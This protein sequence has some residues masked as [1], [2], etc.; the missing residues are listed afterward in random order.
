MKVR[1]TRC[2]LAGIV[3]LMASCSRDDSGRRALLEEA[4]RT[5]VEIARGAVV[6]DLRAPSDT[7]RLVYDSAVSLRERPAQAAGA[8]QVW[9]PFGIA[10][11]DT[12]R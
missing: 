9:A 6:R 1:T 5:N 7:G 3:V 11:P 10:R 8:R 12:T 2:A 4:Q